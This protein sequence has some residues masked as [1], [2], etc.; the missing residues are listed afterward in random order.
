MYVR[1]NRL[2]ADSYRNQRKHANIRPQPLSTILMID[3]EM[4][5]PLVDE[6]VAAR[7]YEDFTH[8]HLNVD[9]SLQRE[10]EAGLSAASVDA[11]IERFI[12]A[13]AY[14]TEQHKDI[15]RLCDGMLDSVYLPSGFR[16]GAGR[17]WPYMDLGD[18]TFEVKALQAGNYGHVLQELDREK[19]ELDYKL[20]EW[21]RPHVAVLEALAGVADVTLYS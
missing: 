10:L 2:L 21:I 14:V 15:A 13:R 9:A 19:K 18:C 12:K 16:F 3:P 1:Y 8:K 20:R 5:E 4:T 6:L 17:T 11:F 7:T